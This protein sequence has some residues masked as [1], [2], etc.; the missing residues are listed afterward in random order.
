MDRGSRGGRAGDVGVKERCEWEDPSPGSLRME[1]IH[2]HA[3]RGSPFPFLPSFFSLT[4]A[5]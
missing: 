2:L 1:Q 3:E 5:P 4:E